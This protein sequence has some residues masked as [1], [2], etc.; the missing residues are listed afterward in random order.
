[1]ERSSVLP[2][3]PDL[4][5][6]GFQLVQCFSMGLAPFG[7]VQEEH[8]GSFRPCQFY[9]MEM[10]GDIVIGIIHVVCKNLT[11]L[12]HPFISFRLISADQGVHTQYIHTVVMRKGGFLVHPVTDPFVIYNMI[13]SHKS[14]QIKGFAGSVESGS[15]H[16]GILADRL[17]GDM[18]V[19]FQDQIRPDLV[20]NY[21]NIILLEKLHGFFQF[22][23]FP[24]PAAGVVG[25]AENRSMDVFR[26]KL[27]FHIFIIHPP[28]SLFIT[29]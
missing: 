16:F 11:E 22:P 10:A 25:R 20:R 17:G 3:Y 9:T 7:A 4:D 13:T 18:P 28:D 15:T 5:S 1:M 26:R 6:C 2:E 19:A 23:A 21:I 29:F 27:P 8:V 24:Y 12:I 14:G